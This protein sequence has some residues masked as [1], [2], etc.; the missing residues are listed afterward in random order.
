MDST[1]DMFK[2][3]LQFQT[4]QG[5]AEGTFGSKPQHSSWRGN[6]QSGGPKR[7][8]GIPRSNVG[9]PIRNPRPTGYV[10]QGQYLSKTSTELS[11]DPLSEKAYFP[12]SES[13]FSQIAKEEKIFPGTTALPAL[14][15]LSYTTLGAQ[16][17]SYTK[18][19]PKCAHDY[20]I[21]VMIMHRLLKLHQLTGKY[22]SADEQSFV[23]S[24]DAVGFTVPKLVSLF[25]N[26][27]GDTTIPSGRKL[28]FSFAKPKLLSGVVVL[29]E[30]QYEIPGFFGPIIQ[31]LGAYA[32]YPC[33]GVYAQ[34]I[35]QDLW[36]VGNPQAKDWDLPDGIRFA[37]RPVNQNC[38]GYSPAVRLPREQ[39]AFLTDNQVTLDNFYSENPAIPLFSGLLAAVHVKM[40]QCRVPLYQISQL[41][42]G[43]QG[44]IP[45]E[46]VAQQTTNLAITASYTGKT[47]SV[48]PS[49]EGHLGTSFL[50]NV[51]KESQDLR[52]VKSLM[53][54]SYRVNDHIGPDA[55]LSLNS[56]Y[57]QSSGLVKQE[58]FETT[59][60]I[61]P[62]RL[63]EAAKVDTSH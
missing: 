27:L 43:S 60:F 6:P 18:T 24:I 20:Y 26:G 38:L 32:S 34:R 5:K 62:L 30:G 29:G 25:A 57:A 63:M 47:S 37:N 31:Y 55:L 4:D 23:T 19:V 49:S 61:V 14:Q 53:P 8:A 15:D 3:F 2:K 56:L 45:V 7:R 44:Q 36:C 22:L 17:P 58:G 13:C 42:S 9:K 16:N 1:T 11:N 48:L 35:L 21:A 50:Y 28:A 59:A 52:I 51:R 33:I 54:V 10:P 40:S 41:T 12:Y 39:L 46:E